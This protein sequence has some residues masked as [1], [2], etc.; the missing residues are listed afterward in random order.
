MSGIFR[1]VNLLRFPRSHIQDFQIKTDLD[2]KY[3]DATLKVD[4]E[5]GGEGDGDV[6]LTLYDGTKS[7]IIIEKTISIKP[8]QKKVSI[9]IPVKNP[10]KW[11]AESPTLY[12][13]VL[14]YKT[15]VIAQKV[16]FRKVEMKDGLIQI[17][18]KRIL[19]RGM[20]YHFESMKIS[21]LC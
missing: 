2:D 15:Q 14:Q 10:A 4:V 6:K 9:S 16:G 17:N 7:T 20:C 19:F 18:G 21:V 12:H 11:T 1:D 5:M 3:V 13:L 8:S